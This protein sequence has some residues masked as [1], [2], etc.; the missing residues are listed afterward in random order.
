MSFFDNTEYSMSHDSISDISGK[1]QFLLEE[2]TVGMQ[3]TM[4][5]RQIGIEAKETGNEDEDFLK[6]RSAKLD[7]IMQ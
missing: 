4:L 5:A 3:T 1:M 2:N 6:K 7:S